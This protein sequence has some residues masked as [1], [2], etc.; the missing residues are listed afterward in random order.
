M[1]DTNQ[2]EDPGTSDKNNK[3]IESPETKRPPG[4]AVDLVFCSRCGHVV[5][6]TG[7]HVVCDSC[8]A[9][10]CPTCGE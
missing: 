1:E 6:A 3:D 10:C 9:R 2:K 8:G 4:G 5:V 7:P